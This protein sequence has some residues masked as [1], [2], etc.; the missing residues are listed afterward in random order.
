[1]LEPERNCGHGFARGERGIVKFG[2]EA[3]VHVLT[4]CRVL[5]RGFQRLEFVQL[6]G[7]A[8]HV[9]PA[10]DAEQL[11][12]R[13]G[14]RWVEFDGSLEPLDRAGNVANLLVQ[15]A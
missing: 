15:R 11:K 13:R 3:P 6:A 9:G 14:Q 1:M 4:Y 5:G 10:Q 2:I 7:R 8:F 12:M